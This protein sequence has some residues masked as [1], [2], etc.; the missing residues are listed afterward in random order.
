MG[1]RNG[2][3]NV[4]SLDH[5]RAPSRSIGGYKS[6]RNSDREMPVSRSI[7]KTNSA[8]TPRL[9]R[10]SQYQTCDCVVPIRSAKGF[11]PPA[12]SQARFSA[13]VDDMGAQYPDLGKKQPKNLCMLTYR[14]FGKFIGMAGDVDPTE[15]GQRVREL[16]EELGWSQTKLGKA[17]GFSQSNIGWIE[18]GSGKP[19]KYAIALA[20][21]LQTSPEW[22]MYGTG[23]KN[24]GPRPPHLRAIAGAL[25]HP[26]RR[27]ANADYGNRAGRHSKKKT[28]LTYF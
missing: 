20:D 26:S 23:K 9:D 25:R 17:S 15:F 18:Q 7:G 4:I 1:S 5:A 10:E 16:R 2:N 22:L 13:S 11:C 19:K 21:A 8:G 14:N 12:S 6:G 28:S 27:P 3:A 24:L